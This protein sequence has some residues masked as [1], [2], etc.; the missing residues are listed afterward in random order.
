MIWITWRMF[1]KKQNRAHRPFPE[2]WKVILKNEVRFYRLLSPRDKDRFEQMVLNF[3]DKITITGVETEIDD[4]DK[5]LVASSA[6]IPLFEFPDWEYRNLNEVLLY[7]NYFNQEYETRG[8]ERNISGMV[9]SGAMNRMMILSKPALH[10]GFEN[11]NSK[12]N[13]GIHEFIHLLDKSDGETDGIPEV[14]MEQ[15]YVIPW[16]KMMHNEIREIKSG[17]SDINPYGATNEA[18]FFS[19]ISEYFFKRPLLLKKNHPEL[20]EI[21]EKVFRID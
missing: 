6:I 5:L 1:F 10:Q 18:E 14:I 13:V 15:Q 3:L 7:D 11:T 4:T 19:V 20:F 8:E 17:H 16:L 2:A 21:L 12:S 9:G